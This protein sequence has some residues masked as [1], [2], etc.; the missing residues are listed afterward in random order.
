MGNITFFTLEKYF[1]IWPRYQSTHTFPK[2][3]SDLQ[4][5]KKWF[6]GSGVQTSSISHIS[7]VAVSIRLKE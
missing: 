7:Y 4:D 6:P 1:H 2:K 3:K 5:L